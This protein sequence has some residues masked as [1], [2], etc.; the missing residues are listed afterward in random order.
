MH[1]GKITRTSPSMAAELA[2]CWCTADRIGKYVQHKKAVAVQVCGRRGCNANA[3]WSR[4][5]ISADVLGMDVFGYLPSCLVAAFWRQIK[6][7]TCSTASVQ[8][9]RGE[10]AELQSRQAAILEKRRKYMVV[11][12]GLNTADVSG[13]IPTTQQQTFLS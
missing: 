8:A 3:K 13:L 5:S 12:R 10:G 7:C 11:M 4:P 2:F 1:S 6:L 9:F